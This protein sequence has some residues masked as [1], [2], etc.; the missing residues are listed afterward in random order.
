MTDAPNEP[1]VEI[2]PLSHNRFQARWALSQDASQKGQLACSPSGE[3]ANLVLRVFF[4]GTGSDSATHSEDWCDYSISAFSGQDAFDLPKSPRRINAALGLIGPSK[5]FS[6]LASAEVIDLP[7]LPAPEP[8]APVEGNDDEP[9]AHPGLQAKHQPLRDAE[10]AARLAKLTG[11]PN[12]LKSAPGAPDTNV[13]DQ[14]RAILDTVLRQLA[15]DPSPAELE[16]QATAAGLSSAPRFRPR[17]GSTEPKKAPVDHWQTLWSGRAPIE[18]RA[19]FIL[20][21]RM[22]DGLRLLLGQTIIEPDAEGAFTWSKKLETFDQ[23]WPLLRIALEAPTVQAGPSLEFFREADAASR[24]LEIHGKLQLSGHIGD[25]EYVPLL[26][27][28]IRIENDGRFS[29]TRLLPEGAIVL[30]GLSLIAG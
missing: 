20:Y 4:L 19:E 7:A 10:V 24:L 15:A 13:S 9:A 28:P 30:P 21:G 8:V 17:S 18:I 11:L 25:P 2:S 23:V 27:D 16:T 12:E 22:A 5:R 29:L 26:P 6:P 1:F 3:A 14:E